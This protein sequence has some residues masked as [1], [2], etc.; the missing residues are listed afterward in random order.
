[1]AI[2]ECWK[3]GIKVTDRT[4]CDQFN[5]P[6]G[7]VSKCYYKTKMAKH[8]FFE[9]KNNPPPDVPETEQ[10]QRKKVTVDAK[11]F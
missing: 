11:F 5:L 7:E 6:C 8:D 2:I 3:H 4:M 10:P 9:A 1:M